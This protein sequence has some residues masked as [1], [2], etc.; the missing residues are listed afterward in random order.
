MIWLVIV[1]VLTLYAIL[2]VWTY[3]NLNEWDKQTKIKFMI[4]G[5]VITFLLSVI[6]VL[7][8][9]LK[10]VSAEVVGTM[11]KVNI[12][13]FAPLNGLLTMPFIARYINRYKAKEYS[14]EQTKRK[15]IIHSVI[16]LIIFFLEGMYIQSFQDTF[17]AIFQSRMQ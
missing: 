11:N 16:F 13:I 17:I 15:I 9:Q 7:S 8:H 12:F 1:L 2:F 14:K 5:T 10:G 4:I 3:Y 6:L